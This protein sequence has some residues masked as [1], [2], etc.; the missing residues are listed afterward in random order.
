MALISIPPVD[1]EIDIPDLVVNE[2]LSL[3]RKAKLFTMTYNQLAKYLTLSWIVSYPD[4]IDVKGFSPYSKESIADNTTIVD[5]NTGA[6]LTAD[7]E[8]NYPGDY[9]GQYDWFNNVAETQQV[10]VHAMIRQYGLQADWN[11]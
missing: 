4:L 9:I 5:V 7:A 3:K 8:G 6:I 10:N 1:I 11:S 2:Q